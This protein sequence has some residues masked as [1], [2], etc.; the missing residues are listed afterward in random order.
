MLNFFTKIKMP[1]E[2]LTLFRVVFGF[3]VA[4]FISQ[5]N[6]N[7]SIILLLIYQFVLMFDYIDGKLARIQKRFSLKWLHFDRLFHRV[8]NALFLISVAI[9]IQNPFLIILTSTSSLLFL[10]TG[11]IS[12][13]LTNEEEKKRGIKNNNRLERI[14]GL[15]IIEAPFSLFFFLMLFN[16]KIFTSWV[17]SLFYLF[18]FFYKF[19]NIV[20]LSRIERIKNSKEIKSKKNKKK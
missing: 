3:I 11:R 8:L 13:P 9:S 19:R 4:F 2:F 10:V 15:F 16:L 7:Y 18:G 12:N 20:F 14:L 17:Y 1:A 6:Y 5:G